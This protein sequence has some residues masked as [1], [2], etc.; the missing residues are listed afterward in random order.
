MNYSQKPLIDLMNTGKVFGEST[1]PKHIQTVISNVFVFESK[2][3]K[4]YK[5]DN[6]FFNKSFRNLSDKEERFSF[7]EKDYKWNSTLSPSVYLGLKNIAFRNGDIVEVVREE[8]EEIVMI[9][10]RIDTNDVLYEKLIAGE[11]SENDCF[12]IGKQ[13][14]ESMKK[15]Q[16]KLSREYNFY[17]LFESRIKD[18]RDWINSVPENIPPEEAKSY[19]DYLENY[20]QANKD[21]FQEL[22]SEVTADGDFHSHNALYSKGNFYLMDT[23][24]PKEEWG[25]GHTLIPLYRLGTDIWALSGKQEFFKALVKGYEEGNGIKVN[26]KFD[27]LYI[28][29]AAG[30][31]MPYLYMLSRTD[32]EK[33]EIAERFHSFT[34]VYFAKLK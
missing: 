1:T 24:P 15:V 10:N 5:N 32:P 3:Y 4:F 11:V 8:A 20:R 18:Q 22:S 21:W 13:L 9:M 16:V 34:R 14:G 19:C 23:Y 27:E 2:V 25:I 33:K 30:I 17:D 31:A 12:E 7:T 29:Y 28:I 6:D 26:R